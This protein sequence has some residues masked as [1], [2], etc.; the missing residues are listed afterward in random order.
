MRSIVCLCY[1]L[2]IAV[3]GCGS[4]VGLKRPPAPV[5]GKLSRGGQPV[6]GILVVFQPL[7][8]GHTRELPVAQDGT[9]R[10]EFVAGEYA[11]Y[12]AKTTAATAGQTATAI[13]PEHYQPQMS[14]TVMVEPGKELTIALD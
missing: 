2:V 4:H 1:L 6:G 10:G 11:Y 3:V 13:A 12:V 14:R 7:G 5:S 8:D 9:F